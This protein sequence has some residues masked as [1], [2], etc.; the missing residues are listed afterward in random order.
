MPTSYKVLGQAQ[1]G[2]SLTSYTTLYTVPAS[3]SAIIS[4][5]SVCNTNASSDYKFRIAISTS[6]TPSAANWIAYDSIVA[7]N[8]TS[9]ITVALTMDTTY[10]YLI[11]SSENSALSF[12]VFGS[13]NS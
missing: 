6:T 4:T 10:K 3:T 13:E 7:A 9:F 8:D 2:S 12:S 11:V 5:I 1:G